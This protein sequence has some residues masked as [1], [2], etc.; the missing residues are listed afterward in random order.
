[1]NK[2]HMDKLINELRSTLYILMEDKDADVDTLVDDLVK[3][4]V[5]WQEERLRE[6][7]GGRMMRYRDNMSKEE[8]K[9]FM[10][11]VDALDAAYASAA[12][13]DAKQAQTPI[14]DEWEDPSDYVGMGWIDSRGR[15]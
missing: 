1:M 2:Q 5:L 15:P 4:L 9:A 13:H 6:L 10:A 3:S 7:K 14:P 12:E 11:E 8:L